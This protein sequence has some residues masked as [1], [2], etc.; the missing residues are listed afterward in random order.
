MTATLLEIAPGHAAPAGCTLVH[1]NGKQYAVTD[2]TWTGSTFIPSTNSMPLPPPVDLSPIYG[3]INS[4]SLKVDN[5]ANAFDKLS[6]EMVTRSVVE[7]H[8]G[9]MAAELNKW[10]KE[11]AR[12]IESRF[13]EIDQALRL[14]LDE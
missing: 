12:A 5:I 1:H 14:L 9:A 7:E 13:D 10:S 8:N 6:A 3:L 2:G 4:L 11:V